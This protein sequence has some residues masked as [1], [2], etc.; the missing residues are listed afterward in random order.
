[1]ARFTG[2]PD[3]AFK[4]Q[5]ARELT[6]NCKNNDL[7]RSIHL[8]AVVAYPA[9]T[10][11]LG[12]TFAL[13]LTSF[14][15]SQVTA[16]AATPTPSTT[17][18]PSAPAATTSPL[19]TAPVVTPS[20]TVITPST[21][22]AT[23]SPAAIPSDSSGSATGAP[24]DHHMLARIDSSGVQVHYLAVDAPMT[25]A[26][27]FQSFRM[28]FKLHNAGTAPLTA[29]PQLEYRLH[30]SAGYTVVP[31]SLL[32]GI[33]FCIDREWVPSA[34]PAGGTKQGPLGE[35]I[36]PDNFLTGNEGGG[37]AM[38]G[39]HSMGANPDRAFTLPSDS[40]SE[41]EFTVLLTMD[42]KYLSTYE[43]RITNGQTA[44]A[45]SQV[46]TISLGAPPTLKLSPGQHKGVAVPAPQPTRGN[47]VA[48]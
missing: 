7:G 27:Q 42:A 36:A 39:H 28:R 14:G 3:V 20:V 35:D 45:G 19:T 21:T 32:K 2:P 30:G 26:S 10:V 24:V 29:A 18:S 5:L 4:N 17:M 34:T 43:F 11:A 38:I 1:V 47:G 9:A 44:L 31:E 23:P 13:A 41:Q 25:D 15:P 33:P 12:V 46:A 8:R 6:V 16:L 22:V 40:Y 37:L 48:K